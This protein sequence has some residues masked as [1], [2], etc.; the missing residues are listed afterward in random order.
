MMTFLSDHEHEFYTRTIEGIPID[1]YYEC[2]LCGLREEIPKWEGFKPN[3]LNKNELK[4][5][6][7]YIEHMHIPYDNLPLLEVIR[8]LAR[9]VNE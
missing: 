3:Q 9:L 1:T 8:K 4:I 2:K 7:K 5:L 6:Y